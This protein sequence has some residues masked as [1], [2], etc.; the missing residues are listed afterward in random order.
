[1]DIQTLK[2]LPK[3]ELIS[4]LIDIVDDSFD[5]TSEFALQLRENFRKELV[6]IHKWNADEDWR[7]DGVDENW[8]Y[9]GVD[10]KVILI[11]QVLQEL[12]SHNLN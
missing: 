9:D 12:H 6:L 3:E 10:E 7:Y 1:M 4:T 8:R 2:Q 11:E 5:L